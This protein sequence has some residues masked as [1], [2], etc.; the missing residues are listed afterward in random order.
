M[1]TE[2][3]KGARLLRRR[4][5]AALCIAALLSA[6][7]ACTVK[8]TA[9]YDPLLDATASAL[10]T[11]VNSFLTKMQ[12]T[13]GTSAGEYTPNADFY[14]SVQGELKTLQLRTEQ[15]EK[16]RPIEESVALLAKS[17][18]DL[19][20]LHEAGGK[21]GLAKPV[22]EPARTALEIQFRALFAIQNALRRGK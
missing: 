7:P 19:R 18:E 10:S 16:A 17:I 2:V 13:A 8:L 15:Q 3:S 21:A 9:D 1:R 14:A 11:K 5:G 12:L 6:A 4:A 22:L 20:Q